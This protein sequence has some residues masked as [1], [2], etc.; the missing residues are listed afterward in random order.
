MRS[1][2]LIIMDAGPLIKLALIDRLDLL[3]AFN[4]HVYIPDEVYFEAAEKFAWEHKAKPGPGAMR[5]A[6]WVKDQEETGRVSRPNT[7]VGES[8]KKRRDSGEYS[9]DKKNHRRNT[10][11]LAAH[12]FF[13]NRENE[14]HDGRPAL[15]LIDD[16][17]AVDKIRLQNL[18]E[19]VLSTFAMLIAL[20]EEKIILSAEIIWSEIEN[21]IPNVLMTH[22]DE[23]IRGDTEYRERMRVR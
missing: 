13:N 14:G 6:A 12:D 18:D 4:L 11:E 10:G 2:D 19:H 7:L 20:E 22:V 3:L 9:P 5:L 8:A 16:G 1:C 21:Q 15:V 23:S 17:P